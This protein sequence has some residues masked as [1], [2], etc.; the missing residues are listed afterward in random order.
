MLTGIIDSGQK[1][2]TNGL[3]LHLDAAQLRSYPTTGTTWTDLSGGNNNGSLVNGPTFNSANGG[4]IVFD[5]INDYVTVNDV[6]GV[7]DFT[8]SQNYTVEF[9][10]Y[11][12]STQG[13]DE[14]SIVEKWSEV[15]GY[16]YI[17]RTAGN[18]P[19]EI[20]TAVWNGTTQ[21]T[22]YVA[23]NNN[24]WVHI[25][26][27]FSWSTSL[28][29]FYRNAQSAGTTP[30]T[31]TGNIDNTSPLNLMR[32]GNGLYY[33]NGEMGSFRIYN[34]ALSASEVLQN[35]NALKSRFGL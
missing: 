9:W 7:T 6:A 31:L 17:F 34:R 1:I 10:F 3:V 23:V 27:T 33:A 32:R 19:T 18:P 14:R 12:N 13:G 4:S 20:Q 24:T 21:Q 5:G 25:C 16:P 11:M 28:L 22:I 29:T 2:I 35:Y 26:V 15:A 8:I 30:L